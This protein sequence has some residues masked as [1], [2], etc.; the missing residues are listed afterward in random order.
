MEGAG[1]GREDT[2]RSRVRTESQPQPGPMGR[3]LECIPAFELLQTQAR[4]L[5]PS[6]ASGSP[7]LGIP[8]GSEQGGP[9]AGTWAF[10]I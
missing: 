9:S 3:D 4:D 7:G 8:E 6:S 10:I 2:R 5:G 1:Q